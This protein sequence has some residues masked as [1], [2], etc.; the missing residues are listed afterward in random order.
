MP[1]PQSEQAVPEL[2][3]ERSLRICNYIEE[4]ILAVGEHPECELKTSWPRGS[5]YHRAE[6]VKDIQATANSAV[7]E[8]KEKY[9]VIGADQQSRTIT[10]C[11]P[12]DYDDAGIRQLVE[13]YLDPVPEFEVLSL[14]SSTNVDFVVLR[15]PFQP[16]RPF[17]AKAQI[18]GDNNRIYLEEGQIWI[19]PGGSE[20][21]GTGKRLV[22]SRQELVDLIDITPRV[23]HE[24]QTRIGRLMPQIR[25][26]ERTRLGSGEA[27]LLPVLTAT[28][29][30]FESYVE[31]L[32][33]G[34]KINHLHV[35]LEKLRDR[36]VLGWQAHF[37]PDGRI[38][39]KQIGA[40]KESDFLPAM[41]R[42][43]L[44][45]LLLIKFSASLQWF[46]AVANLMVEVFESSH[47]LRRA[48]SPP[49]HEESAPSLA[50]H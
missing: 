14:R 15:F 45:G 36:L 42:L 47:G 1:N 21:G 11:N 31:Q 13:N 17:V 41:R 43:V 10:G 38:S 16:Q 50:E 34:D 2:A 18:R 19:K 35:A 26:E 7:G 23:N 39:A 30:E 48:Q 29:E 46:D 28:D 9:I 8:D 33:V 49:P 25:L 24:V 44:L 4:L 22:K 5:Q 27:T 40:I 32:L 37:D 12:A 6:M 3:L 20:T